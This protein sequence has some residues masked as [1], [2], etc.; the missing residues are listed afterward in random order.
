MSNRITN[1]ELKKLHS[2]ID[3]LNNEE[4][5]MLLRKLLA[6]FN[7]LVVNGR[8]WQVK[9]KKT[10]VLE[11]KEIEKE[12]QIRDLKKKIGTKQNRIEELEKELQ[13]AEDLADRYY[14]GYK[15]CIQREERVK[16][17]FRSIKNGTNNRSNTPY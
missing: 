3:E 7:F 10:S 14:E 2:Y 9:A 8:E 4:F 1:A 11:L 17:Y 12:Q 13:N 16:A 15:N 5:V 6:T